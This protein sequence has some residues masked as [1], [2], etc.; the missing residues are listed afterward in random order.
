VKKIMIAKKI[1]II[2]SLII[3]IVLAVS[4]AF[5]YMPQPNCERIIKAKLSE[6]RS[7]N[8][9]Q[10]Q[11]LKQQNL[12]KVH[13]IFPEFK[14]R[15]RGINPQV[16]YF[17]MNNVDGQYQHYYVTGGMYTEEWY[18]PYPGYFPTQCLPKV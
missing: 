18:G 14:E 1:L 2:C 13:S 16:S 10:I 3:L 6:N 17:V 12:S 7:L 8:A 5:S 4:L 11:E 9:T 15:N